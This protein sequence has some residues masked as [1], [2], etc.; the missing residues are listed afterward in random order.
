ML[1]ALSASLAITA[2]DL[3]RLREI[4]IY[5]LFVSIKFYSFHFQARML[6]LEHDILEVVFQTFIGHLEN[7][8]TGTLIFV[9]YENSPVRAISLNPQLDVR[10]GARL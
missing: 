7:A 3:K 6:T 2:M 8:F 10:Y 9:I 1:C 5:W 4:M